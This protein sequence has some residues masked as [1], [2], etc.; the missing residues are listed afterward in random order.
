M[1]ITLA[2]LGSV[3]YCKKKEVNKNLI[4]TTLFFM[5]LGLLPS[6]LML[7]LSRY[8]WLVY[9]TRLYIKKNPLRKK[10][11]KMP[12]TFITAKPPTKNESYRLV[13]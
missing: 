6:S 4:L 5:S 12:L 9:K 13:L 1:K 8:N 11:K 2:T 3:N 7:L 10:K